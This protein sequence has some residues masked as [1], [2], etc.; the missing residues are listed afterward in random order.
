MKK[1]PFKFRHA[2]LLLV[3]ILAVNARNLADWVFDD[4]RES[5]GREDLRELSK[6]IE[7]YRNNRGSYP[8][9]EQGLD[10]LVAIIKLVPSDPWGNKY[11]YRLL[12]DG[13]KHPFEVLSAGPDGIHGNED[14]LS[15]IN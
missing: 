1:S 8:T 12:D 5:R 14:D 6:R 13:G 10:S 3:T 4:I 2:L 9:T 15:S 7:S 11:C